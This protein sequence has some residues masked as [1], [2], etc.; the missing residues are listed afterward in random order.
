MFEWNE[1]KRKANLKKHGIDFDAVWDFDW[2]SATIQPDLRANY[3]ESRFVAYSF[4]NDRLYC[5][6]YTPRDGYTRIISLRKANARE[7]RMYEEE[8]EIFNN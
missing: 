4:I 6:A 1:A 7:Q 2:G 5:L 8:T 3:G